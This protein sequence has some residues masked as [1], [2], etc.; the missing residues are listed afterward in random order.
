MAGDFRDELGVLLGA[1][2]TIASQ[3]FTIYMPDR[4]RKNNSIH[5]AVEEYIE[6]AIRLLTEINLGA[7][8][9]PWAEGSFKRAREQPTVTERT[10]IIYSFLKEPEVFLNQFD[11]IKELLYKFGNEMNQDEVFVE[12]S[13][14]TEGGEHFY[15]R[16]YSIERQTFAPE[17]SQQS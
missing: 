3:K 4:D 12:F 7:T 1:K 8:R 13:G 10:T 17:D 14:E 16:A 2:E 15:Q 11:R 5:P 6:S 9:L